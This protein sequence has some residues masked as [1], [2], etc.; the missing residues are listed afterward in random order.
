MKRGKKNM[1]DGTEIKN[2]KYQTYC[3]DSDNTLR[4]LN[5]KSRKNVQWNRVVKQQQI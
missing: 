5:D 1:I 4:K 3:R 2:L